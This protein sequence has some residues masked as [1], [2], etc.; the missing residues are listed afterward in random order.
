MGITNLLVIGAFRILGA[1]EKNMFSAQMKARKME[2]QK[3][4]VK[5]KCKF[6]EHIFTTTL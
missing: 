3:T 5:L 1:P 2:N 6:T 4:E